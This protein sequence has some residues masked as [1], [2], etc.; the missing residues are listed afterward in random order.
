[1]SSFIHSHCYCCL[2]IQVLFFSLESLSQH[3]NESVSL[4]FYP[5]LIYSPPVASMIFLQ[6]KSDYITFWIKFLNAFH[7][8]REEVQL[9]SMCCRIW[10]LHQM[11]ALAVF[12]L[13]CLSLQAWQAALNVLS[14]NCLLFVYAILLDNIYSSFRTQHQGHLLQETFPEGQY[15]ECD[16]M[17]WIP[18]TSSELK[19]SFLKLLRVQVIDLR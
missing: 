6:S 1:M 5:H 8:I 15:S 3:P 17:V 2:S 7:Y 13:H 4:Q 16:D 9:L 11:S 12:L 10:P 18:L 19:H 14:S